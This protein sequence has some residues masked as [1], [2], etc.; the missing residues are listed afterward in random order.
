M[1]LADKWMQSTSLK[2][3][4]SQ[5][6]IKVCRLPVLDASCK[7]WLPVFSSWFYFQWHNTL[8]M[9]CMFIVW[10]SWRS[11][12]DRKCVFS[13]PYPSSNQNQIFS[14]LCYCVFWSEGTS[15]TSHSIIKTHTLVTRLCCVDNEAKLRKN[16]S[17][18]GKQLIH[19]MHQWLHSLNSKNPCEGQ[20][21]SQNS[22]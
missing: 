5:H 21:V 1:Y 22:K 18:Q 7:V 2:I 15:D 20:M 10:P 19:K 4:L 9:V 14:F 3:K 17:G 11:Q 6:L 12:A 16:T 8:M 13:D